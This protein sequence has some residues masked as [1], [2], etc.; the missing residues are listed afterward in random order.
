M[1]STLTTLFIFLFAA[2]ITKLVGGDVN[3]LTLTMTLLCYARLVDIQDTM[4]KK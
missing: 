2:I 4:D 1:K 3:D